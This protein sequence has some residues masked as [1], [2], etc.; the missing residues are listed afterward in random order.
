MSAEESTDD[1]DRGQV[2]TTAFGRAAVFAIV[3]GSLVFA[4]ELGILPLPF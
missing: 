1:A 4:L 2:A 3:F